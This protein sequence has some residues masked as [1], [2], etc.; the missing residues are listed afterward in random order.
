[1]KRVVQQEAMGGGEKMGRGGSTGGNGRL[2]EEGEVGRFN[3]GAM[4]G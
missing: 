3:R 4:G 2:R 1:M